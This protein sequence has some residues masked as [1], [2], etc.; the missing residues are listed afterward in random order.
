MTINVRN[1]ELIVLS[2]I[3]ISISITFD[4]SENL[5]S[6]QMPIFLTIWSRYAAVVMSR[7][8][9]SYEVFEMNMMGNRP[10]SI[11]TSTTTVLF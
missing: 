11:R 3:T 9:G 7:P 10:Q 4:Q 1:V 8:N 5:M 2:W 6:P